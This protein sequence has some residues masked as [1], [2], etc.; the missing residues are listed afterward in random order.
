MYRLHSLIFFFL[1]LLNYS[2]NCQLWNSTDSNDLSFPCITHRHGLHRKH[3]SSIIVCIGLRK[4]TFTQLFHSNDCTRHISYRDISSFAACWHYL[5]TALSLYSQ[6]A[7][8]K[9]AHNTFSK[10]PPSTSMHLTTGVR[11]WRVARLYS[12]IALSRKPFAR[13]YMYIHKFLL[14]MTG[15]MTSRNTHLFS[16]D[17]L[18]KRIMSRVEW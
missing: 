11:T 17:I 8:S 13:G 16:W 15:I 4:N 2:A 7:L 6:F 5:A 3:S 12:E 1:F 14:R 10:I 18:C 9:Y